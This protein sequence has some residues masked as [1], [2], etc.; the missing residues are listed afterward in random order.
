MITILT[1]WLSH[2]KNADHVGVTTQIYD[3]VKEA[4]IVNDFYTAATKALA[5]AIA[6]EDEA[7]KKTMKDWTV[8]QL[9]STD[10]RQDAYMKCL[11]SML[12]GYAMLPEDDKRTQKAKEILQLWKD[13]AFDTG[14]SYSGESAKVVN[15]YQEVEKKKADAEELH[16]WELFEEAKK[17]AE[18]IQQLLSERFND[19][20]SRNVG[21]MKAARAATD[22]TIKQL[23]QMLETLQSFAPS[24]TLIE[25]LKK[26]RAIE[27]YARVY[28]LKTTASG[29][30]DTPG[31]TPGTPDDEEEEDTSGTP[32][33]GG[34]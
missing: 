32:P 10:M 28:Y 25:L 20:A 27:D 16:V 22:L 24:E 13:Y 5:K 33:M 21:E 11:R 2:L 19:L 6:D 23:Y 30:D 29:A 14:D 3:A 12:S 1:S 4:G 8:E 18:K 7:Y 17:A 26:L 31:G 9:K 34:D 15:M